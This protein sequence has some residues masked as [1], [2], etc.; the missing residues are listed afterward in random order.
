MVKPTDPAKSMEYKVEFTSDGE[1]HIVKGF[2]AQIVNTVNKTLGYKYR[3]TNERGVTAASQGTE[4]TFTDLSESKSEKAE[5]DKKVSKRDY[6]INTS[7]AYNSL[8]LDSLALVDYFSKNK[9]K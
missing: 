6:S 2:G 8:F 5:K 1:N 9:C 4:F 3:N 7:N